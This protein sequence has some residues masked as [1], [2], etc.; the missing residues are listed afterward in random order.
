MQTE[1][2]ST[3]LPG[4]SRRRP[5]KYSI[6]RSAEA[7]IANAFERFEADQ[8][9]ISF[10]GAEDVVLIDIA[11]KLRPNVQVFSLDTGTPAPG[12]LQIHRTDSR[13]LRNP[14]RSVDARSSGRPRP[15]GPKGPVQLL[16][17][18]PPGMLLDPQDQAATTASRRASTPGSPDNGATRAS[19]VEVSPNRTTLHFRQ[20]ITASSSSTRSPAGLLRRRLGI[21]P[22][23]RRALQPVARRRLH[24]HRLRAM[25]TSGRPARARTQRPLVVGR[26]RRKGMRSACT[27][28]SCREV[29]RPATATEAH[30]RSLDH[31]RQ[32]DPRDGEPCGKCR[33]V[34]ER[35]TAG[36]TGRPLIGSWL[37]TSVIPIPKACGWPSNWVSNGRRS[38]WFETGT[39]TVT[40]TVFLKFVKE[41][42]GSQPAN[43][44]S[45]TAAG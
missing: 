9:A 33:D 18:W 24:E 13:P 22:G 43:R 8:I 6:E 45:T 10:S 36:D 30:D 35:L 21:H 37:P 28:R 27:E 4:R 39:K 31:V 26:S 41:V 16:S 29:R 32:K 34:E 20:S 5:W 2:S 7:V 12:N 42:L 25:H 1:P 3:W 19:R 40:Y 15:G 17:G 38:L 23:K 14:Y 11:T 44:Q